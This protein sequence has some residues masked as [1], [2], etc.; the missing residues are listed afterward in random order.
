MHA[1]MKETMNGM[2]RQVGMLDGVRNARRGIE[3][4]SCEGNLKGQSKTLNA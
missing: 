2:V 3:V 1:W 4:Q